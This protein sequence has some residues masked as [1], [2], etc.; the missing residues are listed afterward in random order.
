VEAESDGGGGLTI[1]A[2]TQS[3][4]GYSDVTSGGLSAGATRMY[5]YATVDT[6]VAS[7]G[8][9]PTGNGRTPVI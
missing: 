8:M 4:S 1:D 9:L 6:P 2:A 7:S 3:V 5:M